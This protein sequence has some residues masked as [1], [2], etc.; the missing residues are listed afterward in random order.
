MFD[1]EM[2]F[3]AVSRRFVVDHR[4]PQD[5]QLI[6][7]SVYEIFPRIPR[8]WCDIHAHVLAGEEFARTLSRFRTLFFG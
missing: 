5:A 6:G 4:L 7:R 3:L 1:R 2:L 8:R